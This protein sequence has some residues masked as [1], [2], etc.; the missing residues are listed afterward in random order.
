[1][2]HSATVQILSLKYYVTSWERFRKLK[3]TLVDYEYAISRLTLG[4]DGLSS[5]KF[6][7]F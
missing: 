5:I 6:F 3:F 2:I 7:L 1:M 4:I